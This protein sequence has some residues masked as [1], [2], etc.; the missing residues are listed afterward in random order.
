MK[1]A[2]SNAIAAL[3]SSLALTS[4]VWGDTLIERGYWLHSPTL[5][6]PGHL[7]AG[8]INWQF[9]RFNVYKVNPPLV[10]KVAALP[11]LFAGPKTDWRN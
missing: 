8:L 5:N 10:R 9:G 1:R 6:E 11:V 7:V 3:I 4:L 2:I